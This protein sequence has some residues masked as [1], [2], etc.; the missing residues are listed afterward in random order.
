MFNMYFLFLFTAGCLAQKMGLP[1][2]LVAGV[3]SNNIVARTLGGGD[4]SVKGNVITSLAPAMDI[5]V[6]QSWEACSINRY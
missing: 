3:N 1:I 5:Q 6:T 2:K 4:F